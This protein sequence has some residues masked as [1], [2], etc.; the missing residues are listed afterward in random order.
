M[1][2]TTTRT[3]SHALLTLTAQN[4]PQYPVTRVTREQKIPGAASIR[5]CSN[6]FRHASDRLE[7][8]AITRRYNHEF[9]AQNAGPRGCD[10]YCALRLHEEGRR[11]FRHHGNAR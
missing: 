3:Y 7:P 6:G 10:D 8:S 4:P 2:V 11:P 9:T 1:P 5:R